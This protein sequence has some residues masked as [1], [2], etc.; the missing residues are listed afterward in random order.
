VTLAVVELASLPPD[1][2]PIAPTA[3]RPCGC[4]VCLA[5][6]DWPL[7]ARVAVEYLEQGGDPRDHE[8]ID[9]AVR[10][11]GL[12][13]G[14]RAGWHVGDLFDLPIEVDG[15][16]EWVNGRHRTHALRM[17][18]AARTVTCVD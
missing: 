10:R 5:A 18:G 2:M 4:D 7:I 3:G 12:D 11:A 9:A 8:A 15:C 6:D 17:A 1:G 14:E 16:G 13:P